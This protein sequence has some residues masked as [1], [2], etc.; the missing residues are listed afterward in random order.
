MIDVGYFYTDGQISTRLAQGEHRVIFRGAGMLLTE[1][2]LKD[3]EAAVALLAT[4]S[5]GSVLGVSTVAPGHDYVY[6]P[7]G[8]DSANSDN[9]TLLAFNA[10]RREPALAAYLLGNGYRVYSPV[11]MRFHAPDNWSPFGEGGLNTYAY[12]SGDP[13]NFR[14]STG[15]QRLPQRGPMYQMAKPKGPGPARPLRRQPDSLEVSKALQAF[16]RQ[17]KPRSPLAPFNELELKLFKEVP[18]REALA[19]IAKHGQL[20]LRAPNKR[21]NAPSPAIP[22][23]AFREHNQDVVSQLRTNAQQIETIRTAQPGLTYQAV[24]QLSELFATKTALRAQ[25]I[26]SSKPVVV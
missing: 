24:E 5:Q 21:Q 25:L 17:S 9:A 3:S 11:L 2:R 16:E 7:Y 12:C 15:H 6:T 19:I 8:H 22:V 20:G 13:I 23:A 4:D 18:D 10:E 14:D 26:R 1:L